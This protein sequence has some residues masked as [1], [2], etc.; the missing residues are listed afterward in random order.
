MMDP[1]MTY[2]RLGGTDGLVLIDQDGAVVG[3]FH[4]LLEAQRI[5]W[6]LNA[7]MDIWQRAP[8]REEKPPGDFSRR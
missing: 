2:Y 3:H 4:D 8:D 6:A 1:A 5:V 7:I